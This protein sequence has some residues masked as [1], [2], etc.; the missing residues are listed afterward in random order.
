MGG[1]LSAVEECTSA[2]NQH[3]KDCCHL[4]GETPIEIRIA[5]QH[6][7]SAAHPASSS[8]GSHA[9]TRLAGNWDRPGGT[10]DGFYHRN[11]AWP[12]GGMD[13]EKPQMPRGTERLRLP[14]PAARTS[15]SKAPASQ[16]STGDFD[17]DTFAAPPD[18]ERSEVATTPGRMGQPVALQLLHFPEDDHFPEIVRVGRQGF[19][20]FREVSSTYR[21]M[22]HRDDHQETARSSSL[23]TSGSKGN[24]LGEDSDHLTELGPLHG[25]ELRGG[26]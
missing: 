26:V 10:G 9:N 22:S 2:D 18:S 17:A 7:R 12:H 24:P 3:V 11:P 5:Y 13:A 23:L 25:H 20:T 21:D 8:L 19:S 16:A 4:E 15:A 6:P 1:S 14:P